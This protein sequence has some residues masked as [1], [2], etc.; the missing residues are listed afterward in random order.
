MFLYIHVC[1]FLI[2]KPWSRCRKILSNVGWFYIMHEKSGIWVN[3]R[4]QKYQE[5]IPLLKAYEK[6]PNSLRSDSVFFHTTQ[7]FILRYFYKFSQATQNQIFSASSTFNNI[8][9]KKTSLHQRLYIVNI[10][11][12]FGGAGRVRTVHVLTHAPRPSRRRPWRKWWR[13]EYRE[14]IL[15]FWWF[16]NWL[17]CIILGTPARLSEF[18]LC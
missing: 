10:D 2:L 16:S 4:I 15:V 11:Q 1:T 8:H 3:S 9:S 18:W 5:Y 7:R 13:F 12:S 17:S 14:I 6:K